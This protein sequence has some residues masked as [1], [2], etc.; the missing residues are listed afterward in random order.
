[1]EI[2]TLILNALPY[3]I[4]GLILLGG[5]IAA[6]INEKKTAKEWLVLAVSEAEK[7]FGGGLGELKLREV[8]SKFVSLHPTLAKLITFERFKKCVDKALEQMKPVMQVVAQ[9]NGKDV[10][11]TLELNEVKYTKYLISFK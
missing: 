2:L 5:V 1:M 11:A 6:F 10:N 4:I 3:I 8:H 9:V 7:A